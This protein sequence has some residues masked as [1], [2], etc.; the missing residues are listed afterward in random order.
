M[1]TEEKVGSGFSTGITGSG[2]SQLKIDH[3]F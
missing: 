1:A 2:Q 3:G